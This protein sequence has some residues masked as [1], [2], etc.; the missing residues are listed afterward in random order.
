MT[1]TQFAMLCGELLI[2]ISVALENDNVRAA[3]L[4]GK[5]AKEIRAIL[6]TEF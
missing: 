1:K 2:E 3:L 4:A 6:E 5:S